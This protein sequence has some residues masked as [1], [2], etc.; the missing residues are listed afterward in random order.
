MGG[1]GPQTAAANICAECGVY[2]TPIRGAQHGD[3]DWRLRHDASVVAWR[4]A[5]AS[6]TFWHARL[7]A[8]SHCAFCQSWPVR[9]RSWHMIAHFASKPQ[10]AS[11]RRRRWSTW[12][13]RS[14]PTTRARMVRMCL[15]CCC[16]SR[17]SGRQGDGMRA[18]APRSN[19]R[20]W[21]SAFV[22]YSRPLRCRVDGAPTRG[23]EIAG[24]RRILPTAPAVLPGSGRGRQ[25]FGFA[26]AME[27]GRISISQAACLSNPGVRVVL[28]PPVTCSSVPPPPFFTPTLVA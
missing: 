23:Q 8:T 1:G 26:V 18:C 16:L 11:V 17:A 13:P 3:L 15:L 28:P 12:T 22:Q 7:R 19:S 10:D 4:R 24:A 5:T 14:G 2:C 21:H 27:E 9:T 6:P 20:P 25:N